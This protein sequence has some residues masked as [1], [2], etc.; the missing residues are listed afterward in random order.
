ML[1][2][3]A[4]DLMN[5][6]Y[7]KEQI[8]REKNI[9]MKSPKHLAIARI[10][11]LKNFLNIISIYY[12]FYILGFE[13]HFERGTFQILRMI[14]IPACISTVFVSIA[15]SLVFLKSYA[16][17]VNLRSSGGL[18]NFFQQDR[19]ENERKRREKKAMDAKRIW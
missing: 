6:T 14:K 9:L 4:Q 13:Y 7:R 10:K 17:T 2:S 18:E 3:P 8:F 5:K 15:K 16:R 11:N 12:L 19:R 1:I